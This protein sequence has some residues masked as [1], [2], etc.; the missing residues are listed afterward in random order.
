MERPDLTG[1][2]ADVVAYI[3]ALEVELERGRGGTRAARPAVEED[4]EA[5]YHE[6]PTP[7]SVLT[8]SAGG[9][10]KRTPR[11]LYGR[12][13]RGGMG[14]FD[15]DAPDSDAPVLLAVL[16]EAQ[17]ALLFTSEGRAFRLPVGELLESPVRAKGQPL[18]EWLPLRSGE[19]VVAA[20]P[21]QGGAYVVLA[22]ERGWV[23]RVRASFLGPRMIPGMVFHEVKQ[24]GP[25]VGASW[26]TGDGDVFVATR[27]GMAIRFPEQRIHEVSG[28]LGIRLERGDSVAAVAGV[29]ET[30]GLFLLGDEGK[31]TVRLMSGFAVN[32][33]PGGGGKI[34]LKTE[35]F[36]AAIPAAEDDDVFVISQLSKIIRFAASEVPPKEGVV[37]G[38]NCIALRAD[39]AVAAAV[40]VKRET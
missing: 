17:D 28:S 33:M 34:A 13:R 24:G 35:T 31:G 3:E 7:F 23:H 19:R 11:H 4:P 20:L 37:Q 18:S 8:F 12:Q 26:T 21:D 2:D 38:V 6:P 15:L 27:R 40:A 10:V 22:A 9:L 16:H 39:Q 29:T 1:V 32:K 5:A 14:V 25:L 36:V 30:S